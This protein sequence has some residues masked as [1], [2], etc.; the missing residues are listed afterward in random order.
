MA[1]RMISAAKARGVTN[2]ATSHSMTLPAE[3][4][5]GDY[6]IIGVGMGSQLSGNSPTLTVGGVTIPDLA[7]AAAVSGHSSRLY[8]FVADADT[9]GASAVWAT[10]PSASVRISM[11]CMAVRGATAVNAVSG[12]VRTAGST[13]KVTPTITTN[14]PGVSSIEVNAVFQTDSTA[15][16]STFWVAPAPTN[17]VVEDNAYTHDTVATPYNAMALGISLEPVSTGQSIGAR[18]WLSQ[19]PEFGSAWTVSLTSPTDEKF[20]LRDRNG[21]WQPVSLVGTP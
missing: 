2:L 17:K 16:A 21:A 7:A 15:P 19:L 11:C 20:Y 18:T 9:A 14:S 12:V 8:G 10:S 3:I 13:S 5:S 4:A 1:E 6:V